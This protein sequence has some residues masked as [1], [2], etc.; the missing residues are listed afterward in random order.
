MATATGHACSKPLPEVRRNFVDDPPAR[1]SA[2]G[3][4]IRPSIPTAGGRAPATTNPGI[5]RP[6]AAAYSLSPWSSLAEAVR[7]LSP[8]GAG[9]RQLAPGCC[10]YCI[11]NAASALLK[12]APVVVSA[13]GLDPHPRGHATGGLPCGPRR[14]AERSD[15]RTGKRFA[16]RPPTL[17]RPQQQDHTR[18]DPA[19]PCETC[20]SWIRF[21]GDLRGP[22]QYCDD[23]GRSLTAPSRTRDTPCARRFCWRRPC[24]TAGIPRGTPRRCRR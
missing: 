12:R 20:S 5:A 4:V 19:S 13:S 1:F 17:P 9:R 22:S 24:R 14:I 23:H 2:D 10:F 18:R 21:F 8:Y 16:A 15:W 7:S 11:G 6:G 3:R